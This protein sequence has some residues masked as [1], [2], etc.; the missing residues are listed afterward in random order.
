MN[1]KSAIILI[2]SFHLFS[3]AANAQMR[4]YDEAEETYQAGQ[5][6]EAVDMYR[7]AYDKIPGREIK[8]EI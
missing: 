5:F 1:L 7:D 8:D 2:L 6:Y 3:F 4:F